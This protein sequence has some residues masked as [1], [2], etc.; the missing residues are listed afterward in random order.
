[1]VNF[2][3]KSLSRKL[4]LSVLIVMV[5]G[6][7]LPN[8]S[9]AE[10]TE[11]AQGGKLLQPVVDLVVTFGDGIMDVIQKVVMGTS[12]HITLDIAVKKSVIKFFGFLIGV[13]AFI[14]ISFVSAGI[15]DIVGAVAGSVSG[16]VLAAGTAMAQL[17]TIVAIAGGVAAYVYS[18]DLMS[19]AFLPNI[20]I[21]PTYSVS[22]EEIFEGKLL[23]FDTNFFKPKQVMVKYEDSDGNEKEAKL[24]DYNSSDP[25]NINNTVKYYY[26]I[27]SNGEAVQTSKQNTALELSSVISKWYYAIRNIAVIV[28]MI[29]LLYIG[30]RMML[31]SI[32]SEKSKYKKMFED[33]AVS[34]CLVF[35]LHY[36]MIFAVNINENI[37]DIIEQ[38]TET[39]RN[40]V[41]VDLNEDMKNKDEFIKAVEE[42]DNKEIRQCLVDKDGQ[43]LYDENGEKNSGAGEAARFVWPTNLLGRI[44]MDS[45][46]QDGTSEYVGYAI[47]YLVLVFY[48]VFFAF[49]YLKRVLYLAF[50]TV[51]APLV[52]MTYSIDKIADG[53]AQAFNMWLKEYIFNLL[54]Q[55][56]HLLL[57]MVLITMAYDLASMNILYTLVAIGFMIPAEKFVR[58]MFGFEKAHTPGMLGGAAGAAMTMSGMKKIASMAG[59][60]SGSNGKN[61]GSNGNSSEGPKKIRTADSGKGLDALTNDIMKENNISSGK[62]INNNA[63]PN[64]GATTS[65]ELPTVGGFND[66]YGRPS[67]S[68]ANSNFYLKDQPENPVTRMEREAL[69]EKLADGQLTKDE[70]SNKQRALLGMDTVE[71]PISR[72]Q[73]EALEEKIA[74]GQLTPDDLSDDQKRLLGMGDN[75]YQ[76]LDMPT[77]DDLQD[78]TPIYDGGQSS[79]LNIGDDNDD[80]YERKKDQYDQK[81]QQ[82]LYQSKGETAKRIISGAAKNSLSKENLGKVAG[83]GVKTASKALG[84]GFGAGIGLAAGIASGDITK[85]GQYAAVGATAG[86]AIGNVGGNNIVSGASS[87]KENVKN[88]RE[89]YEKERYG[90]KYDKY[91]KEKMDKDFIKDKEARNFYSQKCSS[92]L[93]GLSGKVREEKLDS[94]MEEAVE[95]RKE[96]VTDNSII[97]QARNLAKEGK[98][99][100]N[101][102]KLAAVMATKAK[103]V[104]GME[105][106][107]KRIAKK[108]GDAKASEIADNAAKLAGFYK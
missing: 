97:V 88:G 101:E 2:I 30:I 13:A 21:L 70:L 29:V 66:V 91:K 67:A 56:M 72:M 69:E 18:V 68:D 62:N 5:L 83:K 3:N 14:F 16:V 107:Q 43:P 53:K 58:K 75:S 104:K 9:N 103:D 52:A 47:A 23:L 100:K 32:A 78:N 19:G 59:H 80:E 45:Q 20:T 17:M 95:Y 24:D 12:G 51:I 41:I 34:M 26:Y 35:V 93:A 36:I 39:K 50:L 33:W 38:T 106:Y 57:Y 85:A 27:D 22:P 6:I 102:S 74:D 54:L 49:S 71:D 65:F 7:I 61:G 25:Q 40:A 86:K 64:Y 76:Q 42:D 4:I 94:I 15:A 99:T 87:I 98:A 77:S 60:S 44:R 31:S 79:M 105:P 84:A 63:K 55:P 37:I 82:A 73:R 10:A 92:E 28:M 8:I 108:L 81:E 46:I 89:A 96:G 90:E 1:M 48:T 11:A